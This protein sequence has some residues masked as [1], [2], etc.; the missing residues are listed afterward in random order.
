MR[1]RRGRQAGAPRSS[2]CA[3]PPTATC[4]S[5]CARPASLPYQEE[6]LYARA[7]GAATPAAAPTAARRSPSDSYPLFR[8]Y[9][10]SRAGAD[11]PREA[12]TFG[13]WHAAQERRWLKNGVQL[14]GGARRR[15]LPPRSAPRACL[16]ALLRRATSLDADATANGAGIVSA[17]CQRRGVGRRA[18]VCAGAAGPRRRMARRLEDAG[19]APQQR[20][21][22]T[23][24]AHHAS[25]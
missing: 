15:S 17:A 1:H 22:L 2:S 11:A 20:V 25:R 9:N 16:R 24:A 6:T 14:V 8:L 23:D 7:G 10:Q 12:A 4:C 21:R 3:W 13:E 18:G 5:R 19:F